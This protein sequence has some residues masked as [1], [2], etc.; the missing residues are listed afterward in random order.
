MSLRTLLRRLVDRLLDPRVPGSLLAATLLG[1]P[2][3]PDPDA[4][5]EAHQA[6]AGAPAPRADAPGEV[7]G[8]EPAEQLSDG[9]PW[10]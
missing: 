1:G 2:A 5:N 9:T 4:E 6:E 10:P 7:S 8:G 3:Q